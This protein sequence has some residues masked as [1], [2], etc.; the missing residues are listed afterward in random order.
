[1]RLVLLN[2]KVVGKELAMSIYLSSG[3]VYA[4]KGMTLSEK[5]IKIL[6]SVGIDTVYVKDE[7]DEVN[8][9]E[10][11]KTPI[12]LEV[13][14]DL[15]NVYD[16]IKKNKIVDESKIRSIVEKI[17]DNLD[18]SENSFLLN[19]VGQKNEDLKLVTHSINVTILSLLVGINKKYDKEKLE[20]L[21]M[22]AILHDVGK[23]FDES[24]EHS[25]IGYELIKN[26]SRI[27]VTAYMGILH[28]H[29]YED[30]TG[31]PEKVKGDKI[32]EFSKIISICNEY[33]NLLESRKFNLPSEVIEYLTSQSG[34]KFNSEIYKTFTESIY[35]YPNGL[36]VKLNNGMEGVVVLQNKNFP[37]RPMI[38]VVENGNP[39]I[40]NLMD[41]L[42]LF[43]EKIVL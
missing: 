29:E 41:N 33:T 28:H 7:N 3:M 42:T 2:D 11:L 26:N 1:M 8:L 10:I 15:K 25:K 30:G 39:V 36:Y 34:K 40:Y 18:V 35:C 19:N 14:D 12:R 21:G 17:V 13:A 9:K 32:H 6:K 20:K 31:Y 16:N 4:K 38:G 43:I 37:T 22:G 27:P 5:V 24:E 23:L